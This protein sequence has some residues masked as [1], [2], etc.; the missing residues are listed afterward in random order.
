MIVK[1][2]TLL[3]ILL[4]LSGCSTAFTSTPAGVSPTSGTQAQGD[5]PTEAQ[6]VEPTAVPITPSI[7]SQAQ[8]KT[9][10]TDSP[11][12]TSTP[13][14]APTSSFPPA[15]PAFSYPIGAPGRPLGDGFFIRHGVAVENTWYNPGWWHTGEDWYAQEGDTAG[16]RVYAVANGEIVYADANYPGRVV[17]IRHADDLY[18]MYGHLDSKLAVKVGQKVAR[19]DLLGTVLRRGDTTP[20]HMH[21]EIRTFLTKS[22]VNGAT[23]RYGYRCGPNC[24]PG[25]GYWPIDALDLPSDL[26]WRNPT[27]VIA[28]RAFLPS[29]GALLGEVV[30]AT[31][32]VSSS[33]TLWANTPAGATRQA[34]GE[35][36]LRPGERFALLEVRAGPE[37]SRATSALGYELWY[38]IRLPDGRSGWVQAAVPSS[39]E[40]GADGRPSSIS[41]NFYPAISAAP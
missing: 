28:H 38:R 6:I 15:G 24:P 7:I 18:S 31:R 33:V 16:A 17:I 1:T 5:I 4:A 26:G 13:K 14:P 3:L 40:T 30:V 8:T 32:P 11:T 36:D 9:S 20:N 19:G 39:F 23:P 35:L 22:E 12:A 25:P 41:F 27:H 21:F 29:A 34:L 37:D 10:P 2:L